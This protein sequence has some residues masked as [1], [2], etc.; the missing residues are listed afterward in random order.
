MTANSSKTNNSKLKFLVTGGAGFIGSEMVR[1]LLNKGYPVRVAD[2]LSKKDA[3]VDSRV[4]FLKLD[5]TNHQEAEKAFQGIDICINA[6]AKI[7]GIGYF[8]KFP[9][10]ILSENNKIYSC[11]FEAAVKAKIKRMVYISSSMVFESA[12]TF[13]SKEEDIIKI[14]PPISAYGF[15]KLS[16]EWYC[17]S[18]WDQYKLPFSICRPFN[19]YGINEFPE[20]EVGYAHV[21]PDL[22]RK[23]MTGQYPLELLGDGQQTRCFTHVKDIADGVI[24]VALHKNAQNEDFNVGSDVEIKMIDLAKKIWE[25]M[26][27]DKPFKVKYVKGFQY[28]IRRRVPNISKMKKLINW[29]QKVKF[30]DGLKEVVQWLQDQK[31]RGKM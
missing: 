29:E 23:I 26:E 15:S 27:V 31:A 6:A 9:A 18:F 4:E 2:N 5:L 28:D 21:I 13:P 25:I 11:T 8:H 7:G 20:R 19:A 16:G 1:Q 3:S 22:V 12:T 10:T 14:P 24:T 30:E 17:H